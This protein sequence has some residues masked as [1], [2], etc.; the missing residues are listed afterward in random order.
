[1]PLATSATTISSLPATTVCSVLATTSLPV[2]T[3]PS[4]ATT[5]VS[6]PSDQAKSLTEEASLKESSDLAAMATIC[7]LYSTN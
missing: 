2:T 3:V 1:M 6:S 4:L 5:A 7:K